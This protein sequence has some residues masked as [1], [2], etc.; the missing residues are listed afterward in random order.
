M[1]R[2][3]GSW[4]RL[5]NFVDS[6]IRTNSAAQSGIKVELP[7]KLW[8]VW[9][10]SLTPP[11]REQP[12]SGQRLISTPICARAPERCDGHVVWSAKLPV[13]GKIAASEAGEGEI[14]Q[15]L[16]EPAISLIAGLRTTSKR[17]KMRLRL[18]ACQPS[19]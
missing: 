17:R 14:A 16:A 6:E 8:L 13:L 12:C 3:R 9:R 18:L 4:S 7:P 11:G 2:M 15:V 1:A 5:E 19:A 10:G